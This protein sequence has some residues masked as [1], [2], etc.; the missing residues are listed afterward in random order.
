MRPKGSGKELQVLRRLAGNLMEERK[1]VREVARLVKTSSSSVSR[2]KK[3]LKEGGIE[4]QNAWGTPAQQ[5]Q[6]LE[7]IMLKDQLGLYRAVDHDQGDPASV[8]GD[9]SS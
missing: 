6:R 4:T 8:L 3:A 2:W 7:G 9:V 1:G 5:K